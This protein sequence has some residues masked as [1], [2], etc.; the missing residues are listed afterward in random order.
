MINNAEPRGNERHAIGDVEQSRTFTDATNS[1][2]PGIQKQQAK[3]H[4]TY[5]KYMVRALQA[6]GRGIVAAVN[7]VDQKGPFVTALATAVIAV[8]TGIYVHYS[9]AQ[10]KAMRDQLPLLQKSADAADSAA[11]IANRNADD[12]ERFFRLQNRPFITVSKLE[13]TTPLES[14]DSRISLSTHN[15][16]RTPALK[17]RIFSGVFIGNKAIKLNSAH[18]SEAVIASDKETTNTYTLSLNE[19][20]AKVVMSGSELVFKGTIQYTDIFKEWHSTTFCA[21]YFPKEKNYKYCENR[22]DVE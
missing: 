7:W 6:T 19:T 16:G 10:W 3:Q 15:S 12:S 9:S 5:A 11:R 8:L 22:N 1:V 20:D 4:R 18:R 13:Q 17:L 14:G 21:R 2:M